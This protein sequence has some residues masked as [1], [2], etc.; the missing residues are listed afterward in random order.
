MSTLPPHLREAR[1]FGPVAFWASLLSFIVSMIDSFYN[2][3]EPDAYIAVS[4]F[5]VYIS[6]IYCGILFL[7]FDES[8][9]LALKDDPLWKK[10]SYVVLQFLEMSLCLCAPVLFSHFDLK[11][12]YIF[13]AAET[14]LLV[15]F[16]ALFAKAFLKKD[17]EKHGNMFTLALD[18]LAVVLLPI[19]LIDAIS[20][21]AKQGFLLAFAIFYGLAFAIEFGVVYIQSWRSFLKMTA[22]VLDGKTS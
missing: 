13:L 3:K 8:V 2:F 17:S 5:C 18:I 15:I 16:W 21:S 12:G 11:G 9:A 19:P 10:R 6:R 14:A 22:T 1:A 4:F 7:S 20:D